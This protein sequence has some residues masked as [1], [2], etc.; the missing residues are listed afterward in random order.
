VWWN[1]C[2]SHQLQ[3]GKW[4][5]L[6]LRWQVRAS[7]MGMHDYFPL[8]PLLFLIDGC[9]IIFLWILFTGQE[10]A[11]RGYSQASELHLSCKWVEKKPWLSAFNYKKIMFSLVEVLF[12]MF[13]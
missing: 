10:L 7:C 4:S 3:Q 5:Q 1:R 2:Y 11:D 8:L 13:C 12:I 6:S 9:I